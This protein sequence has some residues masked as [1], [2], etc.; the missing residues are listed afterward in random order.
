MPLTGK[1]SKKLSFRVNPSK[2]CTIAYRIWP[3]VTLGYFWIIRI[4]ELQKIDQILE[5]RWLIILFFG[6]FFPTYLVMTILG[7]VWFIDASQSKCVT[8]Q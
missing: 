5:K 1:I 6:V 2:N 8:F 3:I 7:F 4:V